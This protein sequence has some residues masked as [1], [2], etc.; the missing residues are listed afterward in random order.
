MA[1]TAY[2]VLKGHCPALMEQVLD[3]P[4]NEEIAKFI[5]LMFSHLVYTAA[6]RSE[7]PRDLE[8]SYTIDKRSEGDLLRVN[9]RYISKEHDDTW[10]AASREPKLRNI[11]VVSLLE[12]NK[13]VRDIPVR[14]VSLL[15]QWLNEKPYRKAQGLKS[16]RLENPMFWKNLIFTAELILRIE[17]EQM[18]K[19][20]M[21]WPE[22][23]D[24]SAEHPMVEG[25][26][27]I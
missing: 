20:K 2:E 21:Q 22:D 4:E 16:V 8:L 1:D 10:H 12:V 19:A 26:Y 15:E 24:L 25:G 14:I 11:N 3:K 6:G 27:L 13:N 23:A 18:V 5:M 17:W 7:D 9:V